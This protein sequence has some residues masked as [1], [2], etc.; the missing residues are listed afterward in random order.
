MVGLFALVFFFFKFRTII[1][2]MVRPAKNLLGFAEKE[3]YIT[4]D[5]LHNQIMN[6]C[7]F[8]YLLQY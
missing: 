1:F 7:L 5:Y 2:R 3:L 8:I 6:V 4:S